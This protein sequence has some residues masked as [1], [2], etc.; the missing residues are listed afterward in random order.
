MQEALDLKTIAQTYYNGTVDPWPSSL[1]SNYMTGWGL[2]YLQ[3]PQSLQQQYAY[4]PTNAKA[5]LAAAG[6]PNGFNTSCIQDSASDG[7]LL[8]IVQ[9]FFAAVGINMSITVMDTVQFAAYVQQGHKQTAIVYRNGG[10]LGGTSDFF[11]S[12]MRFQT[13]YGNNYNMTADPN[14][15]AFYNQAQATTTTDQLK[16]VLAATNLYVAQQFWAT[17]LLQTKT[18]A[19]IQPE[20]KGGYNGQSMSLSNVGIR[21]GF[22]CARLWIDQ[23]QK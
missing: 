14:F 4:N 21:Y 20:L 1:T 7:N 19:L 9:S 8:L 13:G 15:D 22:Y 16:A 17:S 3:W 11:R 23:N 6:F 2:P 10:S 18:Y 12:L 5:L